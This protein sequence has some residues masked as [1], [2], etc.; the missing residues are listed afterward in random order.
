MKDL[1]QPANTA[2]GDGTIDDGHAMPWMAPM[3]PGNRGSSGGPHSGS[4]AEYQGSS[5]ADGD[6]ADGRS[7]S[8]D[9]RDS[10]VGSMPMRTVG[11]MAKNA[12]G[13]DLGPDA[14][15]RIESFDADSD[16]DSF[17]YD[18]PLAT[19]DGSGTL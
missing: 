4:A 8:V 11:S 13:A 1:L 10:G 2:T 12:Y 16:T 7:A 5:L 9:Y 6:P 18:R 14:I 3:R 15:N 19:R 17:K